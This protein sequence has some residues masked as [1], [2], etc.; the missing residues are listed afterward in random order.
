MDRKTTI[1][2]MIALI[3]ASMTVMWQGCRVMYL[4]KESNKLKNNIVKLKNDIKSLKQDKKELNSKY[5][6][7]KQQAEYWYYYNVD[8]AC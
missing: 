7:E 6:Y 4:E 5:Y 1:Y 8:D 3:L 2:L